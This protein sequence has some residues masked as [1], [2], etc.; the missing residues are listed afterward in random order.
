MDQLVQPLGASPLLPLGEPFTTQMAAEQGVTR[1]Q[2]VKM[3]REG[4]VRRVF[5][6]VYVDGSAEDSLETRARALQLVVPPTAIVVE[7]LS[8]WVRGVDLLA[9]GTHIIPPPLSITQPLNRTRV[10]KPGADG[11]RR[12]LGPRDV[13]VLNGIRRTTSLR[14]AIDLARKRRRPR[15]LAALDAM[16]RTGDFTHDQLM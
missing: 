1:N 8:A 6:G 14:T 2:L 15:A 3:T 10:R 4:L 16:L 13:E 5:H 12:M 7:E 9:R 11:T